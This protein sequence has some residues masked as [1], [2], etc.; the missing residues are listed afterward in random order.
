MDS[1]RQQPTALVRT[2]RDDELL[3]ALACRVR[4]LSLQ[5]IAAGWWSDADDP[6]LFAARRLAL[7][8]RHGWLARSEVHAGPMLPL[9]A[10]LVCWA[11]GAAPPDARAVAA[12]LAQRWRTD[13][14]PPVITVFT[15]TRQTN[16]EFGGPARPK[17]LDPIHA[18]HDLNVAALYLRFRGTRPEDA[19]VWIGEDIRP[20]AGYRLKDPDA[21][22]EF[23]DGRPATVIE[24][25]GRYKAEDIEAFH[26]DCERRRRSYEL[27]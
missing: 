21:L 13:Q 5:Q 1:A 23:P 7:L 27:W 8:A 17:R 22:L 11:P 10:P 12:E 15:A 3:D 25:G 6:A 26:S 9:H 16:Q 2:G 4:L 24:L 19:A 20:K 14:A 18:T